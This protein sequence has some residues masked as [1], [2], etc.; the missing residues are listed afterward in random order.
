MG[1]PDIRNSGAKGDNKLTAKMPVP[2]RIV[3]QNDRA[4]QGSARDIPTKKFLVGGVPM[5][6]Q[7]SRP[8]IPGWRW[9]P[10]VW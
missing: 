9:G 3:Y 6:E 2:S 8:S 1:I 5:V 4:I 10:R 7:A